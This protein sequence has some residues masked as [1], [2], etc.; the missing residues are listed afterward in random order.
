MRE[1]EAMGMK[2]MVCILKSFN[3]QLL[4]FEVNLGENGWKHG[5]D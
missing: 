4:L 2:R 3:G 1:G 5:R